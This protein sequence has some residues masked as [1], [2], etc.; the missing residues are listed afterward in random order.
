MSWINCC[1][2]CCSLLV[3]TILFQRWNK[4]NLNWRHTSIHTMPHTHFHSTFCYT[5][6]AFT[7]VCYCSFM[8]LS[9]GIKL[10]LSY[11]YT[12][13]EIIS[14]CEAETNRKSICG[15]STILLHEHH[16]YNR[17]KKNPITFLMLLWSFRSG[18][19]IFYEAE[20]VHD[21]VVPNKWIHK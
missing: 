21:S 10:C 8:L 1:F 20:K 16:I 18:P 3:L 4:T 6:L 17:F 5:L 11:P 12:T 7:M 14:S 19:R 15:Y 9:A 2:V 13:S